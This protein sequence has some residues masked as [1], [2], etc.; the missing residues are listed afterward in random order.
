MVREEL[1]QTRR[2]EEAVPLEEMSK[3]SKKQCLSYLGWGGVGLRWVGGWVKAA[4]R[5]GAPGWEDTWQVRR[6]C[7][8][9]A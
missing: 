4:L 7:A 6:K 8:R 1:L 5:N 2:A 9:V 3:D